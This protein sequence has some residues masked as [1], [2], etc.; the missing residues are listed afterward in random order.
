MSILKRIEFAGTRALKRAPFLYVAATRVIGMADSAVLSLAEMR[1]RPLLIVYQQGRVASTSVYEA[2]VRARPG[3][4][5][6]RLHTL[7]A[8]RAQATVDRWY[9]KGGPVARNLILSGKVARSLERRRARGGSAPPLKIVTIFRDP[10]AVMLSLSFF[11]ARQAMPELF[12]A[13][14]DAAREEALAITRSTLEGDDPSGWETGRW[15]DEVL[16][17]ELGIDVYETPFD[18]RRGFSLRRSPDF[19]LALI[20]FE[21]LGTALTEAT[22]TLIG[23]DR[24]AP[25]LRRAN[26]H[27]VREFTRTEDHIK[28]HL[29]L[30]GAFCDRAYSTRFMQHFYS[31]E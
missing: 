21:R 29:T 27:R 20:K 18:H 28:R 7:S 22:G 14:S 17:A 31:G 13:E 11:R 3:M 8:E 4:P 25:D 19:D 15:L 23:S 26:I 9:R 16:N 24:P 12:A 6:F 1:G 2:L 5:V 30:S 10:I